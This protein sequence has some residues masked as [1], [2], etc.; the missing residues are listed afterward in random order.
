M[1]LPIYQLDAFA[2]APFEGN[3][4]AVCPLVNW[5]PDTLMQSI[6]EENNLA[7]TAFYRMALS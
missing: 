5:L 2:N 3:P 6:A 1:K 4:A 7:E